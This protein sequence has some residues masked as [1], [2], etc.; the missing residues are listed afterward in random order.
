MFINKLDQSFIEKVKI[1]GKKFK[2]N[3]SKFLSLVTAVSFL[4][5]KIL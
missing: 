4:P 1:E 3:Y 2:K 5:I